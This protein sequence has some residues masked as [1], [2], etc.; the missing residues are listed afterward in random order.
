MI[1]DLRQ[2]TLDARCGWSTSAKFDRD[3]ILGHLDS[4]PGW[5]GLGQRILSVPDHRDEVLIL[6]RMGESLFYDF[7][8]I[9]YSGALCYSVPEWR[10]D[11]PAD[12]GSCG[13]VIPATDEASCYHCDTQAVS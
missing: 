4:L 7:M 9:E 10:D 3:T 13:A 2:L 6:T 1:S 5:D 11:E 8:R 12:C